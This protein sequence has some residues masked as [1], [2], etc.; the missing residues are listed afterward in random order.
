MDINIPYMEKSIDPRNIEIF[1]EVCR[2][3][4]FSKAAS[5]LKLPNS[6][7]SRR[8]KELEVQLAMRL[9]NR[10]TRRFELTEVGQVYAQKCADAFR[11][12][13]AANQYIESIKG[14]P[15]GVLKVIVPHD[16]GIY[17]CGCLAKAFH[18]NYPEVHLEIVLKNRAG[19]EDY[20][21]ADVVIDVGV[22][23]A[24]QTFKQ[25]RIFE[26]YRQF[27]GGADFVRQYGPF[28][29]IKKLEG[30]PMIG[31]Y[32]ERGDISATDLRLINHENGRRYEVK[33]VTVMDINSLGAM[34]ELAKQNIGLCILPPFIVR[35][36]LEN[37]EL[38]PVLANWRSDNVSV[39]AVYDSN[40]ADSPK[41][42]V[43]VDMMRELL[44]QASE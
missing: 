21:D 28:K 2:Q 40:K 35:K 38:I 6:H 10:T 33:P 4:S 23:F 34:K 14:V 18:E 17:L 7:V 29:S 32:S 1:V 11:R 24:P 20:A 43:F 19:L 42:K 16:L 39:F 22:T 26:T 9:I 3:Q 31:I 13:T 25:V 5:V 41:V 12:I 37:G 44:S 27:Y 30:C 36:E 15:Q 8:V